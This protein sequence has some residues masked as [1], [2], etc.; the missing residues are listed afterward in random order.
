MYKMYENS[1]SEQYCQMGD[2]IFFKFV[3][4]TLLA[5]HLQT[6]WN[7]D[8]LPPQIVYFFYE[9]TLCHNTSILIKRNL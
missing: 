4:T 1:K 3:D 8:S 9:G 2:P 6:A 5:W 7:F